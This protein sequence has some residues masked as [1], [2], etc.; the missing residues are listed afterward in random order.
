[1]MALGVGAKESNNDFSCRGLIE[2]EK[3]E[4]ERAL[5]GNGWG[6]CFSGRERKSHI[7]WFRKV[8]PG[9]RKKTRMILIS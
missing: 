2:W 3:S 6:F 7:Q 5:F 8:F 1:M 4:A 9:E